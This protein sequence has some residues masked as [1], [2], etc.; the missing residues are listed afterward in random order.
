[1]ESDLFF[2]LGDDRDQ[3]D[4][5]KYW[6]KLPCYLADEPCH[7]DDTLSCLLDVCNDYDV[8]TSRN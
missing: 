2:A 1:M 4:G 5:E 6:Q 7:N 3:S 8:Y